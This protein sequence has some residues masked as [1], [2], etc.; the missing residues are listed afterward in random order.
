MEK[1]QF[2]HGNELA[3][4]DLVQ[5]T[6]WPPAQGTSG[7]TFPLWADLRFDKERLPAEG[8]DVDVYLLRAELSVD[9]VGCKIERGTLYGDDPLPALEVATEN[10]TYKSEIS[11][12]GKASANLNAGLL[13]AFHASGEL[14]AAVEARAQSVTD[15]KREGKVVERRVASLTN[16]RWEVS[17][18]RS[19][20]LKG[21]YLRAP[22]DT[23][24]REEHG[25]VAGPLC[26]VSTQK[27]PFDATATVSAYSGDID[28][29]V[30]PTSSAARAIW[31]GAKRPNKS[32]IVKLLVTKA[33]TE[34]FAANSESP[35]PAEKI[36]LARYHLSGSQVS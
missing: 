29:V 11:S 33:Y 6:L 5:V 16:N 20:R 31:E 25:L 32:A 36:I 19:K 13:Q 30:K 4:L 3:A 8:W 23:S 14:D 1:I 22:A 18:P 7:T 35:K 26:T 9:L 2:T 28:P 24:D 17:E 15:G 12:A 34:Q 21:T 10:E 27:Y